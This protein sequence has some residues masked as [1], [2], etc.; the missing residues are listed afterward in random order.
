MTA[1]LR[2]NV[3]ATGKHKDIPAYERLRALLGQR[4]GPCLSLYQPTYRQFPSSQQNPV[5]YKNLVRDLKAAFEQKHRQPD[6]ALIQPFERLVDNGE[7]WAHPQDGIA[8]FAAPGFFHVEKLQ[9]EVPELVVVN[10]HLYLKPLVRDTYLN[11]VTLS[12]LRDARG[13]IVAFSGVADG[14]LERLFVDPAHRGQGAGRRLV[15]HAIEV[16][17]VRDVD[18][19]EQNA[20]AVGFYRRMGFVVTGRSE[21][22]GLGLP[23]PL[24]HTRLPHPDETPLAVST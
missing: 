14:K 8:V 17:G 10:D 24:L 11:L 5:R 12:C 3:H 23:F 9:R 6:A 18:V 21:T 13:E 2:A 1:N 4:N 19:S 16:Q 15:E 20:Q 7:F 22:D